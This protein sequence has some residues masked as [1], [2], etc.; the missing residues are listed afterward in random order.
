MIPGRS[1]GDLIKVIRDENFDYHLEDYTPTVRRE[2]NGQG[3]PEPVTLV[4]DIVKRACEAPEVVGQTDAL[5]GDEGAGL[6][7]AG[8]PDPGRPGR[9]GQ[10]ADPEDQGQVAGSVGG[11]RVVGAV[12]QG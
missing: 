4:L 7:G 2:D 10:D 6:E 5:R 11:G 12:N 8:G 3:D 9:E 1:E